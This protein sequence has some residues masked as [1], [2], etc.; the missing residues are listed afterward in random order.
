M[1]ITVLEAAAMALAGDC[2]CGIR[3]DDG[4]CCFSDRA[5]EVFA[6]ISAAGGPTLDECE[7][8]ARGDAVVS[9]ARQG[10]MTRKEVS[11]FRFATQK[12][13]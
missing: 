7:A 3:N 13:S 4:T 9:K 10:D 2:C 5:R 12:L 1:P 11:R 6:A 8:I